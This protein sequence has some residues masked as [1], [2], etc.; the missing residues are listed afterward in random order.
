ML[1]VFLT[2]PSNAAPGTRWA[3]I[4]IDNTSV[5]GYGNSGVLTPPVGVTPG[6]F[7]GAHP[8][9]TTLSSTLPNGTAWKVT[10]VVK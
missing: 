4:K 2:V 6:V 5:V 9:A 10:L 7:I 8:G 3:Q 1:D